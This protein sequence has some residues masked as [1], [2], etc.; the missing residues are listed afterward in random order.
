[1]I[2]INDIWTITVLIYT[3]WIMKGNEITDEIINV[4]NLLI[5]VFDKINC[6]RINE[7]KKK[8]D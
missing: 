2:V 4:P 7:K 3:E 5:F 8:S 1:M 6:E